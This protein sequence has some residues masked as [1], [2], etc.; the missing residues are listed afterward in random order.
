MKDYYEKKRQRR[1]LLAQ[2][3]YIIDNNDIPGRLLEVLGLNP[4]PKKISR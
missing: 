2:I 4:E 3:D 1:I